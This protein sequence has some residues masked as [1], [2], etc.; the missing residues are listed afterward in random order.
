MLTDA[1]FPWLTLGNGLS[2][3]IP[4]IQ[5]ADII[6]ALGLTVVVVYINLLLFKAIIYNKHTR[7]NFIIHSSTAAIIFLL[8][9]IYGFIKLSSFHLSDK[10]I[11]VG[12]IQPNLDPWDKWESDNPNKID[13][14]AKIYF[15]FS[16]KA[17]AKGAKLIIW[18][19]TALPVY[20][21]SG[22]YHS[23]IDSI[24]K[25]IN[26][27]NVYLLTGM[28]DIIYYNNKDKI[29]SDAKYSKAGDFYYSTY[30]AILF[31]SPRSNEIRRYGK[32]KLVP[33]GERVP[34]V[35]ELPFLGDMI[36]WSVG[37]SGWNV[38]K[39]T[40]IFKMPF[41][42]GSNKISLAGDSLYLNGLVCYE[43]I[44][45]NLVAAFIQKGA[46]M[47]AVVTNDSWYGNS[48][49][50]YQHKEMSVLRAVENR[51]SVVRAAN[52]GVSTI[53]DPLGR[54]KR[55]TKMF[56]KTFLTGNVVIQEDETFFTKH[57]VIIPLLSSLFSLWVFGIF[58]L[59]KMKDKFNL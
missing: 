34:F 50:P 47:I 54:T 33:F 42:I 20:L 27:N 29:P 51:R 24:Y 48:S 13:D 37:I 46:G 57:P 15:D 59:K 21:M 2:H 25:F 36:K 52:G 5:I 12:L 17:V 38:G 22:N 28:P 35:D 30:N 4:F 1:S 6:G 11:K 7:K 32:M 39:D 14:I 10:K 23:I 45:P 58:I 3:F 26:D 49:G 18:P 9:L 41:P 40:S 8:V 43:S 56:T 19:E 44:Y 55:E 31:F 16:K 53:I